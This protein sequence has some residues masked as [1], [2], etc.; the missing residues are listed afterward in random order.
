MTAKNIKKKSKPGDP[1]YTPDWC[2]EQAV[3]HVLPRIYRDP[4]ASL[5]H[6]LEPGAGQGAFV[7]RLRKRFPQAVIHA[8]DNDPSVGPWEMATESF[9][10]DYLSWG[11]PPLDGASK[12]DLAI[13]NPPFTLAMDFVLKSLAFSKA[14]VFIV[15]HGFMSSERRLRFF[16]DTPPHHVFN[17]AHRPAFTSDGQTD[18][19][20]YAWLCWGG[21]FTDGGGT[22]LHWLP[23]VPKEQRRPPK[24]KVVVA[25]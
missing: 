21:D 16:Q 17:V 4:Y 3:E 7:N 9:K 13:G 22:R 8:I 14:V 20:D 11:M 23:S 24:Q 12:Y 2:V 10:G 25:G 19:A 18:T 5:R 6:I 1:Y 15:R